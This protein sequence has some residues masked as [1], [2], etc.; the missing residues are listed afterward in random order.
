MFNAK[1]NFVLHSLGLFRLAHKVQMVYIEHFAHSAGS[2]NYAT[3][4]AN[5][6]KHF[7]QSLDL[8]NVFYKIFRLC[9]NLQIIWQNTDKV[10][11][12]KFP[13]CVVHPTDCG[14]SHIVLNIHIHQNYF[15]IQKESNQ[16]Q[17]TESKYS[18]NVLKAGHYPQNAIQLPCLLIPE[19]HLT[20]W[21]SVSFI[22]IYYQYISCRKNSTND[23]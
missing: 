7:T 8:W 3:Q 19:Q 11:T 6:V 15:R 18:N 21:L 9:Y 22:V 4:S 13:G 10:Q 14:N 2:I 23:N 16:A 17:C 12:R 20:H 1:C 5:C